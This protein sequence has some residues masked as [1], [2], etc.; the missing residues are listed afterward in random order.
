M[1][2]ISATGS[3]ASP[4]GLD[5]GY[6]PFDLRPP[7]C[8]SPRILGTEKDARFHGA[9]IQWN[10]KVQPGS[11]ISIE[12]R[13]DEAQ[14]NGRDLFFCY[15]RGLA[16]RR[17]SFW[18]DGSRRA[19]TGC[20]RVQLSQG[21]EGARVASSTKKNA[22]GQEGAVWLEGQDKRRTAKGGVGKKWRRMVKRVKYDRWALEPGG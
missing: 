22:G 17:P 16:R 19:E 8:T 10:N 18:F 15:T 20:L 9:W 4:S 6:I 3:C 12:L 14:C 7:G 1:K 13:Y 5:A 11:R 2:R 21:S